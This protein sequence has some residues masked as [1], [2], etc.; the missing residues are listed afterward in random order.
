MISSLLDLSNQNCEC[1]I[2][3]QESFGVLKIL[4]S[5]FLL[6]NFSHGFQVTGLGRRSLSRL[7]GQLQLQIFLTTR[8]SFKNA[9]WS[10]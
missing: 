4:E 5:Y 8:I 2:N 7:S 10:Y 1:V 6:Y 3:I 9:S